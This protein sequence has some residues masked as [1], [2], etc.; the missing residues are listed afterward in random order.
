MV[1]IISYVTP[2]FLMISQFIINCFSPFLFKK[3]LLIRQKL[4]FKINEVPLVNNRL[5]DSIIYLCYFFS[6]VHV[7][8]V[9]LEHLRGEYEVEPGPGLPDHNIKSFFIIPPQRRRKPM[10]FNSMVNI[11][12]LIQFSQQ[13]EHFVQYHI[14]EIMNSFARHFN[15]D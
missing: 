10:L 1:F 5:N 11:T 2:A 15:I 13:Y 4:S 6:R 3:V 8:Q 12:Y 14:M 7:T 9:T